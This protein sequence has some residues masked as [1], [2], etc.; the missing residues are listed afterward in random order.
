MIN[1]FTMDNFYC[2]VFS[3]IIIFII[4]GVYIIK[5][6]NCFNTPVVATNINLKN[7]PE[8]ITSSKIK[9]T[10]SMLYSFGTWICVNSFQNNRIITYIDT[11]NLPIFSLLL[12]ETTNS[13]VLIGVLNI[14][15][16]P[17]EIVITKNFPI[18]EWAYV[19][20][21]VDTTFCDCYLNGK[22]FVSS[23]ISQQLTGQFGSIKFGNF[24]GKNGDIKFGNFN[25]DNEK[26]GDIILAKVSYWHYHLNPETVWKEYS[27]GNGLK[28]R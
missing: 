9:G 25:G 7:N 12:E 21:A 10:A 14:N 20:V 23:K 27:S 22:L 26:N 18:K 11:T 1:F 6:G 13:P 15:N 2:L 19:V 17:Q 4:G 28:N 24:N 3:T 5:M 16:Q 8:D